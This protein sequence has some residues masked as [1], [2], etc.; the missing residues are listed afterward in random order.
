[1]VKEEYSNL[2]NENKI[3]T[4][5]FNVNTF[6]N[7][8]VFDSN[9]VVNSFDIVKDKLI[10]ITNHC[11][12]TCFKTNSYSSIDIPNLFIYDAF[13]KNVQNQGYFSISK[14]FIHDI[15]ALKNELFLTIEFDN[16]LHSHDISI[17]SIDQPTTAISKLNFNIGYESY[18]LRKMS[19]DNEFLYNIQGKSYVL[20]VFNNR[21][22][23]YIINYGKK[24]NEIKD[25]SDITGD[26]YKVNLNYYRL[27]SVQ[28]QTVIL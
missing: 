24:N 9:K 13:N 6:S 23:S 28:N 11:L 8:E 17:R 25:I 12:T 27:H 22:K 2:K 7:T 18:N 3:E 10:L 20:Y 14:R 19:N 15:R 16:K 21:I 1:M 4:Y 5:V 26:Y